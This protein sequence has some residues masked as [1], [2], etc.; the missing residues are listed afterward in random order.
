MRLMVADLDRVPNLFPHLPKTTVWLR[1]SQ[2]FRSLLFH[3]SQSMNDSAWAVCAT[4]G[5]SNPNTVT[6]RYYVHCLDLL[7]AEFLEARTKL[8]APATRT[9]LRKLSGL[10]RSTAYFRLP[11]SA[12]NSNLN[13]SG[14]S[15]LDGDGSHPVPE[16]AFALEIFSER[17]GLTTHSYRHPSPP[18]ANSSFWPKDTYDIV[19]MSFEL[20]LTEKRLATIFNLDRQQIGAMLSRADS[21]LR[22]RGHQLSL[23]EA[24]R[25]R[26]VSAEAHIQSPKVPR[27][28]RIGFDSGTLGVW[29]VKI[30]DCA[31][32]DQKGMAAA[33]GHMAVKIL[34]ATAQIV[35]A[36]VPQ[37]E[38]MHACLDVFDAFGLRRDNLNAISCDG[39]GQA[40]P[41]R[42]WLQNW[43]ISWRI[44][45]TNLTHGSRLLQLPPPWVVVGP[46]RPSDNTA[47]SLT[48]QAEAIWFLVR[49]AAIRFSA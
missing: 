47:L 23:D 18:S 33:L 6:L 45:S 1:A 41:S 4:L 17:R 42:Q 37:P 3:N 31:F 34:P 28:P 29:A 8:G 39:T 16:K 40:S 36:G 46:M 32:K 15:P 30:E 43:G 5:H 13:A 44:A 26:K 21:V 11:P 9:E 7:L 19:W 14:D 24:H 10:P 38:L 20:G 22:I 35:F 27:P 25:N 12:D 49:M 48:Q 2:D